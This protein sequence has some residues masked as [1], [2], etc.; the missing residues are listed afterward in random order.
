MLFIH[1]NLNLI[2]SVYFFNFQTQNSI[3]LANFKTENLRIQNNSL[4]GTTL[5]LH[6]NTRILAGDQAPSTS[7]GFSIMSALAL[8]RSETHEANDLIW[9]KTKKVTT[10]QRI[11]VFLWL[12]AH[13]RIMTN[14]NRKRCNLLMTLHVRDVVLQRKLHCISFE[15]AR[16]Q[17]R[18]GSNSSQSGITSLSLHL[19]FVLGS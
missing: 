7:I 13:G 16:W 9:R 15:I 4:C 19:N 11:H 2:I 14:L 5:D 1:K 10:P 17:R 8:I 18:F 12:L 6:Y 3:S